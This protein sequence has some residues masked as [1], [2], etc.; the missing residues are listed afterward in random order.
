MGAFTEALAKFFSKNEKIP[1]AAE[2]LSSNEFE[3]QLFAIQTAVK[4][5]AAS[6]SQCRFRTYFKA[7]EIKEEEYFLWNYQPNIN[8]NSTE[9]LHELVETFIYDGEVLVIEE[10]GQLFIAD[11]FTVTQ[12]GTKPNQYSGIVVN[13]TE[14]KNRSEKDVLHFRLGKKESRLFLQTV[15]EKYEDIIQAAIT[16][17]EK[18][19]ADKGILNIDSAKRGNFESEKYQTD[20]LQNKFK[21]F[22]GSKSAILPLYSGY[23]YTPHKRELRNTSEVNDVKSMTDEIMNK[24]GQIFGVPPTL[25]KGEVEQNR[26]AIE[27]LIKFGVRPL[28]DMLEEE[29]TRKRY[30]YTG[31]KTGSYMTIDTSGLEISGIFASADK[32]DKIIGSGILTIDEVREKV[33]EPAVDTEVTTT[34]F[35]TKNYDANSV[36]KGENNA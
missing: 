5:L 2:Y 36:G 6:V 21:T 9:F 11:C 18:S 28:L 20:L 29:I 27:S 34:H 12:D 10:K 3:L 26:E 31:F 4:I 7:E 15:A 16:N 33:G 24:T 35:V 13:G 14:F 1:V 30:G 22:F 8:Q 23:T 17:Y 32:L 25:L 19:T